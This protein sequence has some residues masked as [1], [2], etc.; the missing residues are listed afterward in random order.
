VILLIDELADVI[1]YQPDHGLRKRANL[2]LQSITSQGRAPGAAVIGLVQDPRKS[3][4]DFRHLFPVRIAMRLDDAEQV[5]MVLGDGVRDRGAAAHEIDE[6]TP[7]GAWAKSDGR[8]DPERA[9]AFHPTDADLDA[10][11]AYLTAPQP[12]APLSLAGRQVA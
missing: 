7:G 4:V 5:D 6:A 10:L 11:S 3:V 1:A 8:R 12:G 9:R 2:A